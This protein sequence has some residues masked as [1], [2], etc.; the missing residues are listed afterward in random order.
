[1]YFIK[2]RLLR[3]SFSFYSLYF[4]DIREQCIRSLIAKCFSIEFIIISLK[5][6]GDLIWTCFGCSTCVHTVVG[7]QLVLEA[8]LLP[9]PVT[10]IGLLPGVDALVALQ[11]ALI[12]EA[13]PAELTLEWVV[14][15]WNVEKKNKKLKIYSNCNN[16]LTCKCR[17]K[18]FLQCKRHKI[19]NW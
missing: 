2:A 19:Q 14:P 6:G 17:I 4:S 3:N 13:T 18:P 7:L 9:A 5:T 8:E 15:C 16:I 1:M 12:S 11:R 10:F